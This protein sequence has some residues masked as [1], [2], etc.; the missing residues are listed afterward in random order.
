MIEILY[1]LCAVAFIIGLRRLNGPRTARSGNLLAGLGML[2]AVVI[3]L[4][5]EDILNWG[6]VLAG[7]AVGSIFG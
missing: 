5:R 1:L 7:L 2:G 4:I 3:T 6:L